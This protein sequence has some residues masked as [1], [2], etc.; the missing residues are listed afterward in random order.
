MFA[1]YK[2]LTSC[3]EALCKAWYPRRVQQDGIHFNSHTEYSRSEES[4]VIGLD[5]LDAKLEIMTLDICFNFAE[6]LRAEIK[7]K[8]LAL[9]PAF[10]SDKFI[11]SHAPFQRLCNCKC[12]TLYMHTFKDSSSY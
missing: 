10:V 9:F 1:L 3:F 8:A 12:L 4:C 11:C 7:E 2:N 5:L 6:G